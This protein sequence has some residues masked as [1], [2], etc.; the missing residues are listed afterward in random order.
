VEKLERRFEFLVSGAR[1]V[2]H[3][4]AQPNAS[5]PAP[6]R[7]TATENGL[8]STAG[9]TLQRKTASGSL[10][11]GC[12]PTSAPDKNGHQIEPIADSV[13]LW[14]AEDGEQG[15]IHFWEET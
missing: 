3:S 7:G 6:K 14:K 2:A 1:Q 11:V 13:S 15:R 10:F 4:S 9:V 5:A 8:K 12:F